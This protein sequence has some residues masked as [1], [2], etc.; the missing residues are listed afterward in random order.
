ME[1]E[2][3][4]AQRARRIVLTQDDRDMFVQSDTVSKLRPAAFVSLDCLVQQRNQ[5]GLKFFGY[6]VDANDVPVI[7]AHRFQEFRSERFDSHN[8]IIATPPPKVK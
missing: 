3:N 4:P 6:F 8:Q 1:I 7:G 2:I 5:R